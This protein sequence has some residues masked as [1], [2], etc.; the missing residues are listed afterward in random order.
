MA[1]KREEKSA[2]RLL[3]PALFSALGEQVGAM[4]DNLDLAERL[5]LISSADDWLMMRNLRNQMV[6]EYVEDLTILTDA[7]RA[8]HTFVPSLTLAAGRMMAEI[9]ARGYLANS[10]NCCRV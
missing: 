9:E 3:L 1:V 10:S 5:G 6:H 8:A 4:I 7:I 2:L